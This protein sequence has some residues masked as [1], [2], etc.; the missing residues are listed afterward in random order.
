MQS[1]DIKV[2]SEGMRFIF[3][4]SSCATR[5]GFWLEYGLLFKKLHSLDCIPIKYVRNTR[6]GETCS[7]GVSGSCSRRPFS[8]CIHECKAT[9]TKPP[10]VPL[11]LAQSNA[12]PCK[13]G[14]SNLH[15]DSSNRPKSPTGSTP[16][17]GNLVLKQNRGRSKRRTW[18]K[19]QSK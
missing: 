3:G 9:G 1:G 8:L 18:V 6:L 14:R 5:Q 16:R 15:N 2:F 12:F 17:E 13:A 10:R 7:S 19:E 4:S 11:R